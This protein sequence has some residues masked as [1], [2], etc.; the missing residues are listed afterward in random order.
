MARPIT[1]PTWSV[2][3]WT[4]NAIDDDDTAWFVH[5]D[6]GWFG[7]VEVRSDDTD[8]ANYHGTYSTAEQW[9]T[10]RVITLTGMCAARTPER[11]DRAVNTFNALLSRGAARLV[12]AEPV[13]TKSAVVRKVAAQLERTSP[14]RFDWQLVL[15]AADPVKY[16]ATLRA[17]TSLPLAGGGLDWESGRDSVTRVNLA[18]NPV[19]WPHS[20]VQWLPHNDKS[21]SSSSEYTTAIPGVD[22]VQTTARATCTAAGPIGSRQV[23]PG[24]I[25]GRRYVVSLWARHTTGGIATLSLAWHTEAGADTGVGTGDRIEVPLNTWG[26]WTPLHLA[27]DAPP[28]ASAVTV[29]V[30]VAS[31]EVGELLDT[32]ALLVEEHASGTTDPGPYFDGH[33]T[34]CAWSSEPWGSTSYDSPVGLD[35]SGG[36]DWGAPASTGSMVLANSGGAE[37]WPV[38]TITGPVTAP[39]LYLPST[40]ETLLYSGVLAAATDTTP[41]DRLVIDTH[42]HRLTTWLNGR[43]E[44]YLDEAEWWPIPPGEDVRVAFG[45][46]D[47]APTSATAEAEWAPGW[48]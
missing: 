38:Y 46:A 15:T 24:I 44:R 48:W 36:L 45:S 35:W 3:G 11:A 5:T 16:G 40:G 41:A 32:T 6:A 20:T 18:R 12:V 13:L 19:G 1:R 33:S 25:A 2:D 4:G 29:S 39:R 30:S 10:A 23:V 21:V 7:P 26:P 34:G 43:A 14:T 22:A 28:G 27:A 8:R 31:A 42:P 17:S 9:R 47:P 37:V